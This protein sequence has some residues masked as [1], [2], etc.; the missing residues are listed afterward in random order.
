MRLIGKW[1]RAGVMDDGVLQHSETGVVQGGVVSPV[2]ANVFLHHVLDAWFEH[3][4][5]PR[6]KGR[7]FL[8]RYADDCAPR[9]RE[10]VHMT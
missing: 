2:L 10:G 4:V 5:Q 7:S 3:E 9:R 6:L 1:L 8:A